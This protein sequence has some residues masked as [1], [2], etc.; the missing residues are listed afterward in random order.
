MNYQDHILELAKGGFDIV[1]TILDDVMLVSVEK[2]HA[3]SLEVFKDSFG[4]NHTLDCAGIGVNWVGRIWD[5]NN[6]DNVDFSQDEIEPAAAPLDGFTGQ[7][8]RAKDEFDESNLMVANQTP[9][10]MK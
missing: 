8:A 10:E 5:R 2:A 3:N 6:R 9:A 1:E 4:V 7:R